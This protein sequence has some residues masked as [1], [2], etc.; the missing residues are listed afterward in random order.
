MGLYKRDKL[1]WFTITYNGRRVQG[2]TGTSNKKR[3]EAIYSKVHS[4]LIEGCFF[5]KQ[6]SQTITF[7][8]MAEKYL[9]KYQKQRD[10]YSIKH[11]LPFF[12]NM[13]LGFCSIIVD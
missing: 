5:E 1:Y 3:A 12:G 6:K 10:P 7:K 8:E 13:I 9:E 4:D 11:L 2:S